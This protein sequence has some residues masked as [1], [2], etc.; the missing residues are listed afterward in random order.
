MLSIYFLTFPLD[1]LNSLCYPI[2]R[3]AIG[4]PGGNHANFGKS[5]GLPKIGCNLAGGDWNIV[6]EIIRRELKDMDV[7]IVHYDKAS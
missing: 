5:I 4:P 1:T 2:R 6:R 3:S 7:T